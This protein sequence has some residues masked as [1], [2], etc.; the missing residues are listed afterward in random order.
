MALC[1][2]RSRMSL[3]HS[4]GQKQ[5]RANFI[6]CSYGWRSMLI[7]AANSNATETSEKFSPG[8]NF[9]LFLCLFSMYRS[10]RTGLFTCCVALATASAFG[11]QQQPAPPPVQAAPPAAGADSTSMQLEWTPP[12]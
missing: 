11:Q 12:A 6:Q 3:S 4:K 7:L 2:R 1:A 10:A 8:R 5:A 9:L